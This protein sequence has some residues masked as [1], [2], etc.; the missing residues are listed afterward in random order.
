MKKTLLREALIEHLKSHSDTLTAVTL[1]LRQHIFYVLLLFAGQDFLRDLPKE[2]M[3]IN[4]NL[5]SRK[6]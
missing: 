3:V 2:L 5:T 6:K 1:C 4:I